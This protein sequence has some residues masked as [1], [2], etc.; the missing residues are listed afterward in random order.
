VNC[1]SS[2]A[3]RGRWKKR[4]KKNYCDYDQRQVDG[5]QI[6]Q[7][8]QS[9]C[10]LY[11]DN[12]SCKPIDCHSR[13]VWPA[14]HDDTQYT[15]PHTSTQHGLT[16]TRSNTE[17]N[18]ETGGQSVSQSDGYCCCCCCWISRY[19]IAAVVSR[20]CQRLSRLLTA[21]IRYLRLTHRLTVYLPPSLLP[22][23]AADVFLQLLQT[24]RRSFHSRFSTDR[25]LL[26]SPLQYWVSPAVQ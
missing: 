26:T 5:L 18:R 19:Y 15:W 9:T 13:R 20:D 8:H 23:P 12:R 10:P 21:V 1:S 6:L 3:A 2:P 14:H 25:Y 22:S 17:S 16:V 24:L 7:H 11:S 4:K